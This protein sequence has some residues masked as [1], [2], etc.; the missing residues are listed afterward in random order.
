ML[1][2]RKILY[3]TDFSSYSTQAYFHAIA[4]AENH[5]ASLTILY[6]YQPDMHH[7]QSGDRSFWR[8]QLEQIRPMNPEIEVHHELLEG[9]PAQAIIRYATEHLMDLIVLGIHGRTATTGQLMGS[10]AEQVLRD[11]PCSVLTVK[12]PQHAPPVTPM[13]GTRRNSY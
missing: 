11:A 6:V 2:I 10:V 5:H 4:L 8:G 3:P 1:P 7:E 12:L 9:P 13:F